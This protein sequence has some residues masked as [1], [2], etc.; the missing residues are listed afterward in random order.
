MKRSSGRA[1]VW[2]LVLGA[3]GTAGT[4]APPSSPAPAVQQPAAQADTARRAAAGTA[5]RHSDADVRFMQ[6][7]MAHHAQARVMTAMVRQRSTRPEIRLIAERIDVSQDDEMRQMRSWLRRHGVEAPSADAHAHGEHASMPGMLT[8]AELAR[9]A[10]ARG[11]GFDRLF[12]E[13]MIRHHEG[14]VT[15]VAQL[16]AT[17]GAAQTSEMY[18]FATDVN[19]DQRAEIARM[20]ALLSTIPRG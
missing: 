16:F 1:A 12:L 20:R 14:A 15:M 2:V 10:A 3:C 13:Y 19:A 6:H 17:P 8:D 11:A 5:R 7:M 4:E 18:G 9:L